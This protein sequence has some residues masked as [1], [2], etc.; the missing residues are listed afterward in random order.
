MSSSPYFI[1]LIVSNMFALVLLIAAVFWPRLVRWAFAILFLAAGLVN[2]YLAISKP[3]VYVESYGETAFLGIYRDFINGTFSTY[4][5]QILLAIAV[6]QILVAFF[7]TRSGA[8]FRLGFAG[9]C[10]F[11]IAIAPLGLGS[12][13]P[14]TLIL[15]AAVAMMAYNLIKMGAV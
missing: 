13:F 6:G 12:A 14:S 5:T 9:A 2:S 4:D 11:L 7:L 10:V 3:E 8:L 1:P 15:V